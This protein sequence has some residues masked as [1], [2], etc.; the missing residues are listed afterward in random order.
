MFTDFQPKT[1]TDSVPFHIR[2]GRFAVSQIFKNG[3]NYSESTFQFFKKDNSGTFENY[4]QFR[5]GDCEFKKLCFL[6]NNILNRELKLSEHPAQFDK[7]T[8][9]E[10]VLQRGHK[11]REVS[12][13]RTKRI[14]V[15]FF[16]YVQENAASIYVQIRVFCRA[17]NNE[18]KQVTYVS[19]TLDKFKKLIQYLNDFSNIEQCAFQ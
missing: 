3:P 13:G 14:Y 16:Q 8:C 19:Y 12:I 17:E 11:V 1:G 7:N 5:I 4:Q 18:F 2:F 6:K 15:T 9:L 10:D